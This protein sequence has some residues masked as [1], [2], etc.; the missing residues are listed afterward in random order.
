MTPFRQLLPRALPPLLLVAL[1]GGVS[2]GVVTARTVP[3]V[4]VIQPFTVPLPS[5]SA[6]A[7]SA[8]AESGGLAF[9]ALQASELFAG[10]L[11]GW[12]VSPDL[13]AGV[14]HRAQVRFPGTPSVRRLSRAFVAQKRGGSVVE[15]R[16]HARSADEGQ[17]LA[18][19]I[20]EELE[21][22]VAQF[23][24]ATRQLVFEARPGEPL[25]VPV[26]LSP[27]LRGLTASVV[28]FALSLSAVLLWDAL[29]TPPAEVLLADPR[30]HVAI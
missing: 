16:F 4:E 10:T 11:V 25:V 21:I 3:G 23:N 18:R 28:L 30:K 7:E 27:V 29:R 2:V 26:R 6:R 22:R 20:R 17:A 19:A 9:D 24:S 1:A 14:Y 15:V 8:Y 13:V 5:V 12:L